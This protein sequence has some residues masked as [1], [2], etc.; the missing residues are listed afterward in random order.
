ME[1][2]ETLQK[3]QFIKEGDLASY[4]RNMLNSLITDFKNS[5]N[6]FD[7]NRVA[8]D[9][10]YDLEDIIDTVESEIRDREIIEEFKWE[11]SQIKS[12]VRESSFY[13]DFSSMMSFIKSFGLNDHE[14]FIKLY[15][16]YIDEVYGVLKAECSYYDQFKNSPLED[17]DVEDNKND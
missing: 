10:I 16:D 4:Y 2:L 8:C 6:S 5:M 15:W 13:F 3:L 17:E 9:L 1:K 12:N 11:L 7:E 14:D